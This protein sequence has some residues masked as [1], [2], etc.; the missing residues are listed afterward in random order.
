MNALASVVIT[1]GIILGSVVISSPAYAEEVC[2]PSQAYTETI[3]HP[4]VGD[5]TLTVENPDYVPAQPGETVSLWWNFSPNNSQGP[6][7]G[8]PAFPEDARGTWQGPHSD[9]GP[10]QDLTGTFQQGNGNGSW[11][12]RE[13]TVVPEI[14]AVGE[15]TITVDNP[16]YVPASTETIE[17][18]AVICE[19]D[20]PVVV[21]PPA[22]PPV[23]G[24]PEVPETV[25]VEK[26]G[27]AETGGSDKTGLI[28]FGVGTLAL[29]SLLFLLRRRQTQ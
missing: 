11:F 10:G 12:H 2:T 8:E 27:L 15:P 21:E 19:E 16:D 22:K 13:T 1:A 18:E 26:T 7:E 4:A 28:V 29:G 17:H 5:P 3:K 9:G 24:D 14:P 23:I 25:A 6:L 20:P